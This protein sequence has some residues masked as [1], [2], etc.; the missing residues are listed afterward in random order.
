VTVHDYGVDTLGDGDRKECV[1]RHGASREWASSGAREGG[2]A[3]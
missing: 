2:H 3:L 1:G